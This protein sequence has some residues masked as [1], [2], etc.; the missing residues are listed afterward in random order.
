MPDEKGTLNKDAKSESEQDQPYVS[1][2]DE[3]RKQLWDSAE[4]ARK[5]RLGQT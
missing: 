3:A 4:A 5:R 1:F 2:L